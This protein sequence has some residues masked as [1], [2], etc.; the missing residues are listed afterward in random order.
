MVRRL[1]KE[2]RNEMMSAN[3]VQRREM[4][5]T[6]KIREEISPQRSRMGSLHHRRNQG[7]QG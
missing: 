7:S 3:E 5:S 1:D 2:T 4:R 6:Q